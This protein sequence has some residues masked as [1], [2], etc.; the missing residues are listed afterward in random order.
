MIVMFGRFLTHTLMFLMLLHFSGA[1]QWATS[2]APDKTAFMNMANMAEEETKKEKD[3]KGDAFEQKD[4]D[5]RHFTHLIIYHLSSQK[6][7]TAA[8]AEK[9]EDQF[10]FDKPTP[11]PDLRS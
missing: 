1:T 4:L 6:V 2:F 3:A 10:I 7:R 9:A 8:Y 11:P 5:Q